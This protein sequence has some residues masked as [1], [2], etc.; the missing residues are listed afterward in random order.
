MSTPLQRAEKVVELRPR[1]G[2]ARGARARRLVDIPLIIILLIGAAALRLDFIRSSGF[3]ID[4]DEAIVGLMAKHIVDGAALPVFYYGQHY[5]GSLEPLSVAVLFWLF[6]ASPFVLQLT[7]LIFSLLFVVVMYGVGREVGGVVVGRVSA[8]LSAFPPVALVVWSYKARGGFIELLV[9]GALSTLF[10]LRWLKGEPKRWGNASAC[11]LLLG[12]GWWV[13]NQ[14]VYFIIP[15]GLVGG[16]SVIK[17]L[18]S[19]RISAGDAIFLCIS[20]SLCF[21]VGGAPYWVYNLRNGFPSLGMF[22][23]APVERIGEHIAGLFTTALPILLGAKRFWEGPGVFSW[24][25]IAV[26]VAYGIVIGGVLFARR[27]EIVSLSRGHVDQDSQVEVFVITIL[28][29]CAVFCSSTFGWLSQAPRYLLPLYIPIFVLCGVWAKLLA[30]RSRVLSVLGVGAL[31]AFNLGSCYWGGRAI[32]GEPVVFRGERVSR[33]HAAIIRELGRLDISKVRT[34]YWIGYRLA[35]ET[36]ERVTFMVL[37]EPRQVRIPQYQALPEGVSQDRVPLL[38][39]PSERAT[40]VGALSRLGYS[41]RETSVDG[42]V[43]IYDI[44]RPAMDLTPIPRDAIAK[45]SASGTLAASAAVDGSVETR[46][47]TGAPQRYGQTFEI[48]LKEP[49]EVSAIRWQLGSWEQDYPRGLRI[50]GE[51]ESG[52]RVVLL[53]DGEYGQ[54][55]VFFR[56]ADFEFWFRPRA[57]KKVILEQ[58]GSHGILDWSLAEVALY[59]GRVSLERA[60]ENGG[61]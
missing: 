25:T 28:V 54:L 43:L 4:G 42:Y 38:L 40:F 13:N 6:G 44:E 29:A 50:L 33:D 3:V 30:S 57:L 59:S 39:V 56:G 49:R 9:I 17:T 23:F 16:L 5:M 7:P 60:N 19:K 15:L 45:V 34:N 55:S 14:I 58:V 21:L 31:V 11:A 2:G 12:I 26:Y 32:P 41:F 36:N 20:S 22:A 8:I 53:S 46:W 37:Q 48:T 51:T 27:R 24:A 1:D 52:D 10:F 61:A 18:R 35:F 47:A